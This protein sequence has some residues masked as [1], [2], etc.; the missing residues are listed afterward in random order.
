VIENSL[1]RCRPSSKKQL[2]LGLNLST[3]ETCKRE[4]LEEMER[5]V[6]WGVLAQIAPPHYQKAK[7]GRPPFAT[8]TML[9]IQRRC[10]ASERPKQGANDRQSSAIFQG[11]YPRRRTR[12]NK[13][14]LVDSGCCVDRL[15]P[16]SSNRSVAA[17]R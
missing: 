17:K 8:E 16:C 11:T 5:V 3:K 1:R 13:H 15:E 7:T 10:T 2:R 6:P 14:I 12:P 4:F 9:R